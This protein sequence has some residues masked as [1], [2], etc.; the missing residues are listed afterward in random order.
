VKSVVKVFILVL[1]A[2]I[3]GALLGT[4]I[5]DSFALSSPIESPLPTPTGEI[6]PEL[7]TPSAGDESSANGPYTPAVGP[8]E[9]PPELEW[10]D[11]GALWMGVYKLLTNDAGRYCLPELAVCS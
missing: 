1:L 8:T 9:V 2:A 11:A 7:C 10:R 4:C 3:G 6:P 5:S